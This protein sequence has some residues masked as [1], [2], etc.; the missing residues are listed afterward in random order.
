[1]HLPVKC[2]IGRAN[3]SL[4]PT[5]AVL[6]Y[7]NKNMKK[8]LAILTSIQSTAC[9][10]PNISIVGK[11]WYIYSPVRLQ[12]E[13]STCFRYECLPDCP[14]CQNTFLCICFSASYFTFNKHLFIMSRQHLHQSQYQDD[15]L[16]RSCSEAVEPTQRR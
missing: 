3:H 2:H 10:V 4:C 8:R 1:M 7:C 15:L 16:A 12:P 5:I 9:Y 14:T 11:F 6:R 13:A